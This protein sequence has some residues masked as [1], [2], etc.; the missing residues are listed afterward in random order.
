MQRRVAFGLTKGYSARIAR[1]QQPEANAG[2]EATATFEMMIHEIQKEIP[3]HYHISVAARLPRM[4][5]LR[6]DCFSTDIACWPLLLLACRKV[7]GRLG[8]QTRKQWLGSRRHLYISSPDLLPGHL[9][10]V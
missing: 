10:P 5:L 9:L 1:L 7:S 3:Q 6:L 2:S 4:A 8:L